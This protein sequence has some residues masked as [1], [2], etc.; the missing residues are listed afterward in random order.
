MTLSSS[1]VSVAITILVATLFVDVTVGQYAVDQ[2]PYCPDVYGLATHPHPEYCDKF[3]LCENGT[4]TLET[5]ENGLLCDGKGA[6]HNHCNYNWGVDCGKRFNE[7]APIS[8]PGCLYQFGIYS[9][10]TGCDTSYIK[11][12]YGV[13]Y[14]SPCTP[15][16]V[17]DDKSH[18][19]IWADELLDRCDPE[20]VVGFRCPDK[21]EPDTIAYKFWPYPRF[22]IPGECGRL[23]TCVNGYPRLITCGDGKVV[24]E[25]SLTCDDP[26]NVPKCA[27]Y[28]PKVTKFVK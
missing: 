22:T 6:V 18:S 21:V 26:I 17:Y 3:Y 27:N 9:K 12:A 14:E 23:I 7:I 28:Y 13:P 25:Y 2:V 15:G 8:T 4:L 20:H 10:T 19:C 24:D 16:L 1:F 5:C 11:C